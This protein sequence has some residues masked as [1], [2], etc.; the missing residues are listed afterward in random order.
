MVAGKH[1]PSD[2]I[3][4]SYS[5]L[6]SVG[7][8]VTLE[9]YTRLYNGP[10]ADALQFL[11]EHV[12]GRQNA[13]TARNSLFLLQEERSKSNLKQPERTRADK[14]VARLSSTKQASAVHTNQLAGWQDKSD[15][16]VAQVDKLQKKLNQKR[17]LL[18][19]LQ[20]LE[21]KQ[22]L[23][24]KRVE[25]M[26]RAIDELKQTVGQ[27]QKQ[28]PSIPNLPRSLNA[29]WS[30]VSNTRDSMASLHAYIIRLSRLFES[31]ASADG[32]L[33]L[34]RVVIR[35]LGADHP[36]AGRAFDRCIS[37]A[38]ARANDKLQPK[39]L[40]N[41]SV[42][43]DAKMHSNKEKEAELQKLADLSTALRLL[44]NGHVTS[45]S[46]FT[47]F[48]SDT[49]RTSL[50]E[51]SRSSKGHVDISRAS[52]VAHG[53]AEPTPESFVSLVAR[54]CRMHGNVQVRT[55]LDEIERVIKH[56]HRRLSLADPSRLPQP[57]VVDQALMAD[58]RSS[59]QN[60]HDR[61]TKL[62]ARKTEKA[63]MGRSLANDVEALLRESRLAIGLL[64]AKD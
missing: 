40:Q 11:S 29:Q 21:E 16:I 20:V 43:L 52:I 37:L 19:L 47:E 7:A 36:D 18:L 3:S 44:S 32:T 59:M 46:N 10:L 38:H 23:R 12:V 15:V 28:I 53:F 25:E 64:P 9:E 39:L 8:L 45:I 27:S 48:V 42:D 13:T 61:A 31:P 57:V 30:R 2:A 24:M 14:A 34:Q 4:S 33:R 60:A 35:S 54:V 1:A 17:R 41:R 63:G 50:Q 51:V 49:L 62:L 58:Y 26:T 55:I 6:S 5:S 22:D 56:S